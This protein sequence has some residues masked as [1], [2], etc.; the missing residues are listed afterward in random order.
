[1]VD[2]DLPP[3]SYDRRM[4]RCRI[5]NETKPLDAFY[6]MKGTPR[7]LPQRVQGMQPCSPQAVVRGQLRE[8]DRARPGL[9][10]RE[11]RALR[12]DPASVQGH[13]RL[14]RGDARCAP[15]AEVR[16]HARGLRAAARGARGRLRSVREAAE[17]GKV[18]PRRSRPR[19]R[20]R[21]RAALLQ[22]QR[23]ARASSTTTS[24]A[25]SVPSPTSPPNDESRGFDDGDPPSVGPR[26]RARM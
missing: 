2:P 14:P 9:A 19:D 26:R 12:G 6:A 23:R 22:V 3:S 17:A 20:L 16:H 11:S 13:D 18:A 25:S 5:C 15:Q 8:G 7:R 24:G 4:K 10:R 21:A 1:M